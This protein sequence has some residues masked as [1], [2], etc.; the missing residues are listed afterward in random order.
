M[1]LRPYLFDFLESVKPYYELILFTSKTKYYTIPVMKVIQNNKNYFDFI[2]YREHCII[3]GND[4]VKDLT[5][6]GRSLDSTIIIDNLPQHFKLQKENGI[7]IKSF[8]AQDPGDRAL[9]DLI[10]I[11]VNIALGED[12][13]R[14]GLEKYKDDIIT[15]I[16]SNIYEYSLNS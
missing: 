5:R 10:P 8:W 11:L 14:D 13:V 16:V 1:K 4:Y 15:K 3:L 2:F 7:N 9:Y 6:I 12:D